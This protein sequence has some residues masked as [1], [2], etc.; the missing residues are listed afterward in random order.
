MSNYEIR[1]GSISTLG[2]A[3]QPVID[4]RI[5]NNPAF[6]QSHDG[7]SGAVLE[8]VAL[9][10]EFERVLGRAVKVMASGSRSLVFVCDGGIHRSVA[11]AEHFAAYLRSLGFE[12]SVTHENLE[13]KD[14]TVES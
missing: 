13:P 1:S 11:C 5:I 4:C 12:V 9:D 6:A 3:G 2:K 7:R 10:R 8:Y 14:D